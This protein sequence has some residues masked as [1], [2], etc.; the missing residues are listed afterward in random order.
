MTISPPPSGSGHA[1]ESTLE[2]SSSSSLVHEVC[3]QSFEKPGYKVYAAGL[4]SW[5]MSDCALDSRSEDEF[6]E[7]DIHE[8]C[9]RGSERLDESRKYKKVHS[10]V[11]KAGVAVL[12]FPS[13]FRQTLVIKIVK[14]ALPRYLVV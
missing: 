1:R 7:G 4:F 3:V 2:L 14:F 5:K 10:A 9:D 8:N 13:L 12:T 11:L 6:D